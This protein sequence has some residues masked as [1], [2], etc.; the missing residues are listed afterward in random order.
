MAGLLQIPRSPHER[1]RSEHGSFGR[2]ANAERTYYIVPPGMSVIFR[3]EH[4]NELKR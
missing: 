2:V 1:G 4:G 3:D